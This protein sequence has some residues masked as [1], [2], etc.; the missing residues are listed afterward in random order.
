MS[1]ALRGYHWLRA[2]V[3]Q[4]VWNERV[5]YITSGW[6]K[7]ARVCDQLVTALLSAASV[8]CGL[9]SSGRTFGGHTCAGQECVGRCWSDAAC[10]SCRQLWTA[11]SGAGRYKQLQ[12]AH[13]SVTRGIP[14]GAGC[15]SWEAVGP[16]APAAP[17]GDSGGRFW[18]SVSA[19]S[20]EALATATGS[21]PGCRHHLLLGQAGLV[22]ASGC[23][24]DE[25]HFTAALCSSRALSRQLELLRRHVPAANNR[26]S[27]VSDAIKWPLVRAFRHIRY[28][29]RRESKSYS[30]SFHSFVI[31]NRVVSFF[32]DAFPLSSTFPPISSRFKQF[33]G[34]SCYALYC[35]QTM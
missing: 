24:N 12:T 22:V 17:R 23:R 5:R 35:T 26:L 31:R 33:V 3:T 1:N 19:L 25:L 20:G 8:P 10:S 9:K 28:D 16:A 32:C 27:L 2:C 15:Q 34:W 18:V 6:N 29:G 13:P 11:L 21:P 4:H 7:M 30:I 14:V